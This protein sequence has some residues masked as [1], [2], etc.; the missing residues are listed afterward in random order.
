[1]AREPQPRR[2]SAPLRRHVAVAV[3]A[4]GGPEDADAPSMTADNAT[5]VLGVKRDASF[6]AI[7]AAK[8]RGLR[9]AGADEAR[10]TEVEMA[11]DI[12]LMASLSRRQSG[13]TVGAGIKYADVVPEVTPG[14]RAAK[15]LEK[16]NFLQVQREPLRGQVATTA[17]AVYGGLAVW[18]A[19]GSLAVPAQYESLAEGWALQL[20]LGLAGATWVL[21]SEKRAPQQR[22]AGVAVAAL[23][24]GALAGNLL[25]VVVG[26]EILDRPATVVAET[27]LLSLYLATSFLA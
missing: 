27:S 21:T 9:E 14:D 3:T 25:D 6:D 11:Y 5:K 10:R 20:G 13:V 16:V 26:P 18:V 19:L 24:V 7:L 1:L 23:V 2:R 22:A 17:A 4:S 12:L 15:V 8:K